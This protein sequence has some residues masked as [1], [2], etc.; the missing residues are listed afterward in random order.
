MKNYI[1]PSENITVSAPYDVQ[2]GG[3]ALV[4]SVFGVAQFDA[5]IGADVVLVRRG[6]FDLAKTSAQAWTV[7]AKLY[8]D[9][10]NK[11][12]TTTA[13]GNILIG[14]AVALAANPSPIGSVLLDGA[15]R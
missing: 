7:G 11:V 2:A 9:D 15:I 13:S 5:E 12:V 4:G 3:G 1:A 6:S 14:A 8:W 10:T